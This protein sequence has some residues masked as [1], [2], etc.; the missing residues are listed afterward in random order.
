MSDPNADP[1]LLFTPQKSVDPLED[2]AASSSPVPLKK[3]TRQ[4]MKYKNVPS[5]FIDGV[6]FDESDIDAVV[7]EY[8]DENNLYYF[9][10]FK[11]SGEIHRFPAHE[12]TSHYRELVNLY[13]RKKERGDLAPFDPSSSA[14]HIKSRVPL[15]TINMS[16]STA[17]KPIG[18]R[19][20][21]R[22]EG[23]PE[24]KFYETD[25]L[26]ESEEEGEGGGRSDDEDYDGDSAPI[27]RSTRSV[28][29]A[30][31]KK[32]AANTLPYSPRKT[33]NRPRPPPS[34]SDD[35]L[36]LSD[37]AGSG[38]EVILTRRS[39]RTRNAVRTNLADHYIEEDDDPDDSS[40]Y[41]EPASRRVTKSKDK[42]KK[43]I[44]RGKDSRPAYGH[45]RMVD[46]LDVDVYSDEE[47]LPL[48]AH[49]DV[50]EKC[51]EK[52]AHVQLD[53]ASKKKG[54]KKGRKSKDEED[55]F[56]EDEEEKIYNLG[57]WV[58]C[59]KC[60]VAAHWR[61][62]SG[63][64]RDEILKAARIRDKERWKSMHEGTPSSDDLPL[65][66]ELELQWSTEFICGAC[67]KGGICMGCGEVA[68]EPDVSITP[69][70]LERE[71]PLSTADQSGPAAN[72]AKDQDVK[73][74]DGTTH[75]ASTGDAEDDDKGPR[76]L[77]YRCFSC[78]RLAHY[79]HLPDP[80]AL[81]RPIDDVDLA[82]YYQSTTRWRCGDCAS[83]VYPLDKI[84]AWRPYPPSAVV[85]PY[86]AVA[87]PNFK[88][89]LPREYLVKWVERSYRRTQWVP[90]MWLVSTSY[91]KLKNFL[92]SG[93][94]VPLLAEPVPED[95]V[96][97]IDGGPEKINDHI[98][99]DPAADGTPTVETKPQTSSL[100]AAP[101]AERR[102]PPA[103][104]TVDRV[105]DVRFWR[106]KSTSSKGKRGN[107][108]GTKAKPIEVG[109]EGE[110]DDDQD[111]MD[112]H[113]KEWQRAFDEGEQPDDALME[114]VD[115]FLART[116]ETLKMSHI[117]NV[118]WAFIKWDDLGYDEATWDSP[119]RKGEPGYAAFETAFQRFIDSREVIVDQSA[120][121]VQKLESRSK[122]GYSKYV[123][124]KDAQPNLGQSSH[125]NLMP[126]QIDGFNWLCDNWWNLQPCILA[127]E[128]GLGK[129]V[130]IVTF[131]GMVIG[132]F[133]AAP[134]LVVVPNSTITNWVREFS[135]WA[136]GLRVVP[137][138]GEAKARQVIADYELF[139]NTRRHGTSGI[140]YH[141]LITTYDAVTNNRDF[142]S[143]FKSTPRWEVLV[144]D[145]GQR[146]KSD[147]SLLF[148]KLKELNTIQR[149]IMTG[150]PLNNNIRELF[151]LMNFLDPEKW[152]DLEVLAKEYEELTDELVKSLHARL[153][154]YFLRRIKSEV[155]QLPPK[156]E[157]IVPISMAPLQKEI[158]RSILSQNLSVLRSLTQSVNARAGPA[159]G[160]RTNMNNILMQ[161]RKC[162]QHPYLISD[163]IEPPNLAPLE[164]HE[165]LID[166]S[167]KLRLLRS[168]LPK[169]KARGHRVL[170]FSQFAIALNIVEDFVRGEGYNYLRLDG[171]TKQA[172][173]QK[174]MDEFN[175][176]NSE[177]FIYLLTTR[178]GGV[179][180]NLFTAD[181][182]IIFDPDFNPHQDLQ[183]IARSHRYGQKKTCLVFKL[184][185]KASAEERIMQT[186]K[187]KLILDHV[188][189]QKMDDEGSAGDDMKS[190]LT[191]GAK[192]LFEEDQSSND[193]IYTENDIEKL[194][195]KTEKEGDQEN[196]AKESGLAFS[197]A[198]VW[199]ADKDSLEEI[200]DNVL[201]NEQGDSWAQALERI[202]AT[203]GVTQAKEATGR[204]TR[205]RAAPAFPQ[206][207]F[208]G[209]EG[210]EDTPSKHKGRRKRKSSKATG[211][212]SDDAYLDSP[213]VPA[214]ESDASTGSMNAEAGPLLD[215]ADRE[216]LK[217]PRPH[218]PHKKARYR[219]IS[220]SFPPIQNPGDDDDICGLC[221]G[222]HGDGVCYMTESSENL[223]EY[224]EI[225]LKHVD[226]ESLEERKAAIDLI[227]KT[228]FSRGKGYLLAGQPL[229]LVEPEKPTHRPNQMSSSSRATDSS[230]KL[231]PQGSK[232][233][234]HTFSSKPAFSM[235][236]PR[237]VVSN[238]LM[239]HQ[240]KQK[241]A[242]E[243]GNG[244][245]NKGK[246]VDHSKDSHPMRRSS[247]PAPMLS[248]KRASSPGPIA[249]ALPSKKQKQ[250]DAD[251]PVCHGQYHLIKDCDVVKQGSKSISRAIIRLEDDPSQGFTVGVL[252]KIFRQQKKKEVE[253]LERE[254]PRDTDRYM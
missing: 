140:K 89:M 237:P 6:E 70:T 99:F 34:D 24:S 154:P 208:D 92:T 216:I 158:Y 108:R 186:G 85:P 203:K 3:K 189:V 50:C 110:D 8:R 178:A 253:E 5:S 193:I 239:D 250:T 138:Y 95:N 210:L 68:L 20:P 240:T 183:A 146:L 187:K 51:H 246:A 9:A 58:R 101:D 231:Q 63:T 156:N 97:D 84:L 120:K 57:G 194:V 170:L 42:P 148:K 16:T 76:E 155:L 88:S 161:L 59:L 80:E 2:N 134:A 14:V 60:P 96:M 241:K 139:H 26:S 151:N 207:N 4:R 61:C 162:L 28:T 114:S 23:T 149:V 164:A 105:L 145:E 103:W 74:I 128:M 32:R 190:I 191:F 91:A 220:P 218:K 83:L 39:G 235:V 227:E 159:A 171:D 206:Q 69:K 224:R 205:R 228:L 152:T 200:E 109:D 125:L 71:P 100:D 49:R 202:A 78:K 104:K 181:T 179:G 150:T 43:K 107:Q 7:G 41:D 166:A 238:K 72:T 13:Q 147:S 56:E 248:S 169:L 33:R 222:T 121:K 243:N 168:L 209:I 40:D 22:L 38:T 129:T 67:M 252:R 229:K 219:E 116:K 102:I 230:S 144:V 167:A 52:P 212:D 244:G 215:P 247:S 25:E 81:Q 197:F 130:Q 17:K 73:M 98:P 45:F 195:E 242:P 172:D 94:K 86:T 10:R 12:F 117:K 196:E 249:E 221:G 165:K 204:G 136:P 27:R 211:S 137:F 55:N 87:P 79:R 177:V 37:R 160:N 47:S 31:M 53:A 93:T 111:M 184:M 251:C 1:L 223:V 234:K 48:R 135:R 232:P 122:E 131:L 174:G 118:V 192:A 163:D 15:S 143:V 133:N 112:E 182:V 90:H 36:G 245:D 126:F 157:V 198:K 142:S 115:D 173:R 226:N 175:R 75:P 62:L 113:S 119:P 65:R 185:V 236:P 82:K 18:K 201:D 188:I 124:A 30:K 199:A 21:K 141:V 217:P 54:R 77:L 19:Q 213:G 127:D 66:K 44:N 254:M 46:D 123:L 180:I 64:Q 233:K 29:G 214:E 225:L 106:T 176:P 153:R 35:E 11:E 132:K